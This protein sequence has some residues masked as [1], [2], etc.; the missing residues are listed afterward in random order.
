MPV[1][2]ECGTDVEGSF[3][4]VEKTRRRLGAMELLGIAGFSLMLS[5]GISLFFCF[6]LRPPAELDDAYGLIAVTLFF[7]GVAAG[8]LLIR[9]AAARLAYRVKY[10]SVLIACLLASA[11]IPAFNLLANMGVTLAPPAFAAS[12]LLA[13]LGAAYFVVSW[14]DVCGQTRI[15]NLLVF[16]SA[17]FSLSAL[18]FLLCNFMP[19]WLQPATDILFAAMSAALLLFVGSRA[20]AGAD[21]IVRKR[22]DIL[23]AALEF[24]PLFFLFG[25]AFGFAGALML[26]QGADAPVIEAAVMFA[27]PA[28]FAVFAHLSPSMTMMSLIRAVTVAVVGACLLIAAAAG[29]AGPAGVAGVDGAGGVA[30]VVGGASVAGVAGVAGAAGSAGVAG[31]DGAGGV[32]G[33]VG[34][35]ALAALWVVFTAANLANL[36]RLVTQQKLPVFCHISAG[37]IPKAAGC[38][39]GAGIAA[40]SKA[41]MIPGG[42]GILMMAAVFALVLVVMLF[43]PEKSHHDRQ[44]MPQDFIMPAAHGIGDSERLLEMRCEAVA[45]LYR[46]SPREQDVLRYLARG[47]NADYICERLFV[48]PNTVKSHIYS[49]YRKTDTHSQQKVMDL[50][51]EYPVKE[52]QSGGAN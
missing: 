46:L 2:R 47:R 51:D 16:T 18:L 20:Q 13:G 23:P 3:L 24:E 30:G 45:K 21:D 39:S 52:G 11:S 15:H 34:V 12:S 8:Y 44:G 29:A 28:I 14:L 26:G 40:L 32:A 49:I 6:L 27:A 48:S 43:Y 22:A 10:R 33:V 38:A 1:P 5:W 31:V 50:V 35:C 19:N 17:S 4:A 7:A 42:L 25:V 37:L 36:L 9:L 41:G